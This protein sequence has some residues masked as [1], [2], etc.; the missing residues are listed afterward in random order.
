M[1]NSKHVVGGH[2]QV[3]GKRK[4]RGTHR[5]A[6]NTSITTIGLR[7]AFVE[8]YI[9]G[10]PLSYVRAIAHSLPLQ[11]LH[12]PQPLSSEGGKGYRRLPLPERRRAHGR[13]EGPTASAQ[14][15]SLIVFVLSIR[16]LAEE[17][18]QR[19]GA[20]ACSQQVFGLRTS[21]GS[22]RTAQLGRDTGHQEAELQLVASGAL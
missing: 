21:A 16:L 20:G 11:L 9:L 10:V 17:G 5:R 19:A 7:K 22:R 3:P 13:H 8:M 6:F 2:P 14:K 1:Q 12:I 15:S 18:A 4:S